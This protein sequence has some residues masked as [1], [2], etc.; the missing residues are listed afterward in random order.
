MHA[1]TFRCSDISAHSEALRVV[2]WVVEEAGGVAG[3]GNPLVVVVDLE[4][5]SLV[6][7]C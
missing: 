1:L 3:S 7:E 6:G 4:I 5:L 2:L